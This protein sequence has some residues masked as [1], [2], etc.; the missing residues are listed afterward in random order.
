MF[1][2]YNGMQQKLL[3]VNLHAAYIPFAGHSLNLVGRSAVDC[4][5]EA[6]NFFGIIHSIYFF[7]QHLRTVGSFFCSV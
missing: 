5:L 3:E 2:R 6:V 4:S 1:G 7:C